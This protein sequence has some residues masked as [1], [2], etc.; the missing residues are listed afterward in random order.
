MDQ[1]HRIHKTHAKNRPKAIFPKGTNPMSEQIQLRLEEVL[2]LIPCPVAGCWGMHGAKTAYFYDEGSESHVLEVWP[3]TFEEPDDH[4]GNGDEEADGDLCFGMAEFEFTELV[5]IVPLETFHFSQTR[6]IFEIGWKE[7][8][9]DLEL[10]IHLVPEEV[11]EE[12]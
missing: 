2:L 11:D 1:T 12:L 10:R 8:D 6:A 3:K 9:Q 7:S 4:E 5:K